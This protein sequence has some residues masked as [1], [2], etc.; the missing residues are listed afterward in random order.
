MRKTKPSA[1][2]VLTTKLSPEQNVAAQVRNIAFNLRE[3]SRKIILELE[4]VLNNGLTPQ[5]GSAPVSGEGLV[6][7]L[8]AVDAETVRSI[9][10]EWKE[11]LGS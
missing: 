1:S 8:G 10:A 5:D 11:F 7:A 6:V 9:I 3:N 4:T 2:V